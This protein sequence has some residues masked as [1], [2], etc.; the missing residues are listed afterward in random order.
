M[1]NILSLLLLI[2]ATL[3]LSS[4]NNDDEL[5]VDIS[6]IDPTDPEP[7]IE[8]PN[9]VAY[10]TGMTP[11]LPE[12]IEFDYER[13]AFIISSAATG[14]INLVGTDGVLSNLVSPALFG[15]NGTFGLQIDAATDRLLA[16]SSNL[17]NPTVANLYIFNLDDGSLIHNVD[18]STFSPGLNFVNDVA[19]DDSGNAYVTNSDQGIIFKV[20]MEGTASIF[21]QDDNF[22]TADPTI[23]TGF[24]GIEYHE[25]NYLI[26]SHY[27][28]N[29]IF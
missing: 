5:D 9:F 1:H 26:I 28:T 4:C 11:I 13:E 29:K 3:F 22:T 6:T 23:E 12:G 16:V 27:F 18:L 25:D 20:T 10:N 14:A 21:F 8:L 17:Q 2:G 15:G 7:T 19:V 24:N